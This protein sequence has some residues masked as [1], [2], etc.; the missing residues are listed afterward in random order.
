ML[1]LRATNQY[2]AVSAVLPKPFNVT[3]VALVSKGTELHLFHLTKDKITLTKV[4]D[5]WTK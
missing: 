3:D 5:F 1:L 2:E 4:K